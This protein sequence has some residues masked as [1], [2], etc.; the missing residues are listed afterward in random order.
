ME[1]REVEVRRKRIQ[2]N[3][4]FSGGLRP[5]AFALQMLDERDTEQTLSGIHLDGTPQIALAIARV[6]TCEKGSCCERRCIIRSLS[7]S[8]Q[9]P[10]PLDW[11]VSC[12]KRQ[13]VEIRPTPV[14]GGTRRP[15]KDREHLPA[16]REYKVDVRSA[17]EMC[18]V[19]GG[20]GQPGP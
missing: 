9:N 6:G 12:Y 18:G 7:K 10:A 5:H 3:R 17:L 4:R 13:S 2:R 14:L 20:I 16:E 15:R 11:S 19:P 1:Q 8:P